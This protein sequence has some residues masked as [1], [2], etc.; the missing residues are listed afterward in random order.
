MRIILIFLTLHQILIIA[1][2]FVHFPYTNFIYP[3]FFAVITDLAYRIRKRNRHHNHAD[4]RDGIR[5]QDVLQRMRTRAQTEALNLR[6]IYD[7]EVAT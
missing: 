7:E 4:E 6:V 2:N 3:S 5:K 1:Q